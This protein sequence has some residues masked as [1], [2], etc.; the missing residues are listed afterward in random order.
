MILEMSLTARK[1]SPGVSTID[2]LPSVNPNAAGLDIGADQIY[3]CVPSD[4]DPQPVRAF[5]TFT[6]DLHALAD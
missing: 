3:A 1:D 6:V 2:A 5:T 4:R